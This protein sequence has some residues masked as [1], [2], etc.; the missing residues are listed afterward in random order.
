[1]SCRRLRSLLRVATDAGAVAVAVGF[2]ASYVPASLLFSSTITNGGDMGSH[3]Y[4]A[5]YLR[6]VLLPRGQLMG[7]CLGNYAGYRKSEAR[8]R[9]YGRVGV[10][11]L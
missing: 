11:I 5:F 2:A 4:P 9:R 8:S 10:Q 6:E 3:Y 7:W 1:M